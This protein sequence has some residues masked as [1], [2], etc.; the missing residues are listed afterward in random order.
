M[1][2]S[3]LHL[4]MAL[5]AVACSAAVTHTAPQWKLSWSD[6]FDGPFL[7]TSL[8]TVRNN[9]SHCCDPFGR[10]ELQLYVDSA[11][12]V[13]DGELV[14]RTRWNPTPGI[15]HD[16][17]VGIFNYTS[18]FVDTRG[19]FAQLQG[20]FV[21]NCSLPSRAAHGIWPAFWLLPDSSQCWPTGGEVDVFEMVGD[22]VEDDIYVSY[23]WGKSCS[24]DQAPIPGQGT[25]PAGQPPSD[26]QVDW[27]LYEVQWFADRLDFF[28]DGVLV[29]SRSSAS[30]QLPTAPMYVIF[31]QAVDQT[32]FS[33]SPNS[34]PYTG[35]GV[36][37]RVAWVRAYVAE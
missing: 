37:L 19:A 4:W 32:F 8:W 23:H 13:H 20:R 26:W 24:A 31:D 6:E 1:G 18:G 36:T 15:R 12:S 17:S 22:P 33:P 29:M 10:E 7:N 27:H 2:A 30:V 21:A 9:H 25:R 16:G 28:F 34:S 35:D 3:L 5:L 11:V 14:L